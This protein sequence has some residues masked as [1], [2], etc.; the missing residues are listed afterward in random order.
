M[1][2]WVIIMFLFSGSED[3]DDDITPYKA[4]D[5]I[6]VYRYILPM[7]QFH[8]TYHLSSEPENAVGV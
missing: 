4:I 5:C 1:T 6:M 2:F 8:A 3:W 7:G